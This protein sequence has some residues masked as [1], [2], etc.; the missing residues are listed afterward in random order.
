VVKL[1][2]HALVLSLI[3]CILAAVRPLSLGYDTLSY[4][5]ILNTHWLGVPE[6]SPDL[7][8]NAYT[9]IFSKIIPAGSASERAYLI[10]LSLIQTILF[11]KILKN[12][13]LFQSTVMMVGFG[14]IIF[15]DIVRQGLAMLLAGVIV[16]CKSKINLIKIIPLLIHNSGFV[17]FTMF[18]F[19]VLSF[20]IILAAVFITAIAYLFLYEG[21]INRYLFYINKD[22]YIISFDSNIFYKFIYKISFFNIVVATTFLIGH[23]L[24]VFDNKQII[25]L[26]LFYLLSI[27]IP[28]FFRLYIF[29][30]FLIFSDKNIICFKNKKLFRIIFSLLMTIIILNFSFKTNIGKL[31][32]LL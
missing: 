21:A 4:I 6:P 18:R 13:N 2:I 30:I 3:I 9:A 1:K 26:L 17:L 5:Y 24:G 8:F 12:R 19:K 22:D 7:F 14:P 27:L 15:F 25:F 11:Y 20:K 10:V 32:D 16:S 29:Y 23:K 28:I 31:M